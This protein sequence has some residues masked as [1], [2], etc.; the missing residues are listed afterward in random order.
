[1]CI[2]AVKPSSKAMFSDDAIRQMFSRNPDGAGLMWTENDKVYIQ[3]GFMSVSELLDFVHKK[4]WDNIPVVMH[5]R[6]MTSGFKDGLNCH[7]YPIFKKNSVK[8]TCKI[9]M[10][11]N[12]VLYDYN[13]PLHSAIN[14][15]QVFIQKVINELPRNF[16]Q[17][18][19]I[20]EMIEKV[21]SPSRLCF[22]DSNGNITRFGNWVEDDGYFYSNNSYVIPKKVELPSYYHYPFCPAETSLSFESKFYKGKKE[23]DNAAFKNSQEF[24]KAVE[25]LEEKATMIDDDVFEFGT[26]TYEVDDYSASIYRWK[27]SLI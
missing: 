17:N 24:D 9:G 13:P 20:C 6:I 11:H 27:S 4:S 25:E 15:T 21:A 8:C 7:P 19:G 2:I 3:K 5:F 16:L 1:M 12:G 26:Y 10:A 23:T 14:D 22:L 18:K